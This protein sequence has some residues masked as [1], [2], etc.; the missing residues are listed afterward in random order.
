MIDIFG[1]FIIFILIALLVLILVGI[2]AL[3]IGFLLLL[4]TEIITA[5]QYLKW[6]TNQ[7]SKI[8]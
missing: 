4:L 1:Y 7:N 6:K 5:I 3:I 8:E 2:G